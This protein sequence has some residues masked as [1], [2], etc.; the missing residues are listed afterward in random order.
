MDTRLLLL[1]HE[2]CLGFP[3]S[4]LPPTD[5]RCAGVTIP[6]REEGSEDVGAGSEGDVT[7]FRVG[8]G[9]GLCPS[10]SVLDRVCRRWSFTLR[11]GFY[12]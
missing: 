8:R 10:R 2:R 7:R 1:T 12:F 9:S 11:M 4:G 5:P 6:A 3:L